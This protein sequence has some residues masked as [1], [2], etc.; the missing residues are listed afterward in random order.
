MYVLRIPARYMSKD[1]TV[2][3]K[4]VYDYYKTV[5]Q[6]IQTGTQSGLILPSDRDPESKQPLFTLEWIV[7]TQAL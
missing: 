4:A 2:E 5:L 1:A 3:D 6:D 7:D